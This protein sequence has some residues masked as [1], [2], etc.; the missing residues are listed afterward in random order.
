MP[1][2]QEWAQQQ[3]GGATNTPTEYPDKP[4][5]PEYVK[6]GDK[7]IDANRNDFAT[8]SWALEQLMNANR[9]NYSDSSGTN[10]WSS[11][12]GL[13]PYGQPITNWS[14]T[15]T[16]NPTLQATVD[17]QQQLGRDRAE[18]GGEMFGRVANELG[19]APDWS[20]LQDWG[21]VPGAYQLDS[22]SLD[23]NLDYSGASALS[24]PSRFRSY[25]FSS[26]G[27]F[28][29]SGDL[30]A[31]VEDEYY[32]KALSRLDPQWE[33]QTKDFEASMRAQGLQPGDRQW[34][35]RMAQFQD[36]RNDAYGGAQYDAT[37]AG[38]AEFDRASGLDL[39]RR[40]MLAEELRGGVDSYNRAAQGQFGESAQRRGIETG[41]AQDIWSGFNQSQLAQSGDNR[42][43]AGQNFDQQM[44]QSQYANSLRQSQMAQELMQ[45]GASLNEINA[46]LAGSQVQLPGQPNTPIGTAPAD[47]QFLTGKYMNERASNE[48]KANS[49]A[50]IQGWGE[51][52]GQGVG[53]YGDYAG[54]GE[55]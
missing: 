19:E 49:N 13:D 51:L 25:D 1:T 44:M 3:L 32:D 28:E 53:L 42:A 41:E 47:S 37:R 43:T 55:E 10:Q 21:G 17:A 31:R 45:R 52:A 18:M 29:D 15:V 24:D 34:D 14:N 54:W 5:P 4:T 30:R 48:R 27:D 38:G 20:Q 12:A 39:A 11:E 22:A 6:T 46:L 8:N 2:P 36:S 7:F 50:Q 40:G 9:V 23:P 35:Q 16:L 26:L 33:Q